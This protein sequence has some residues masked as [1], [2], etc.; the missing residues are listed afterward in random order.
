MHTE[1]RTI[2]QNPFCIM[3]QNRQDQTE[4]HAA[5]P[6][7][8]PTRKLYWIVTDSDMSQFSWHNSD[9]LWFGWKRIFLS[10]HPPG[11]AVLTLMKPCTTVGE[12]TTE[13]GVHVR[14]A[15]SLDFC[16][17]IR[18]DQLSVTR[19][20]WTYW[21]YHVIS[22]LYNH[23]VHQCI[24]QHIFESTAP[25]QL[26]FWTYSAQSGSPRPSENATVALIIFENSGLAILSY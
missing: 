15:I 7:Q 6:S 24:C 3:S 8:L 2:A 26:E 18:W 1:W 17:L 13:N 4:D 14:T 9:E 19:W 16:V 5:K 25:W 21:K 22:T 11:K 23:T 10:S 20:E 12:L